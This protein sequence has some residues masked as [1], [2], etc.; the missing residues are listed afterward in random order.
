M[1]ADVAWL[2]ADGASDDDDE[3]YWIPPADRGGTSA[4]SNSADDTT[5]KDDGISWNVAACALLWISRFLCSCIIKHKSFVG[6]S[7]EKQKEFSEV[8]FPSDSKVDPARPKDWSTEQESTTEIEA[9]PQGGET[10]PL[11]GDI[12]E[13]EPSR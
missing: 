9:P 5:D 13:T 10:T 3:V 12:A 8:F 11:L 1:T 2:P 6:L 4:S 7:G